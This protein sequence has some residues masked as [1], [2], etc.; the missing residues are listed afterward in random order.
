MS[1]RVGGCEEKVLLDVVVVADVG[2]KCRLD[3]GRSGRSDRCDECDVQPCC[4]CEG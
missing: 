2:E 3:G 1:K 4:I